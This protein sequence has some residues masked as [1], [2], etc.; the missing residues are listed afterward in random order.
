MSVG[1]QCGKAKVSVLVRESRA[2]R[3]LTLAA[4]TANDQKVAIPRE[5]PL[6]TPSIPPASPPSL[7]SLSP[8]PLFF[9]SSLVV[10]RRHATATR[11]ELLPPPPPPPPLL[12]LTQLLSRVMKLIRV[13]FLF[14]MLSP[15]C[16][17][18][19]FEDNLWCSIPGHLLP[20][21][22]H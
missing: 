2:E 21:V 8:L 22:S 19:M 9:C 6:A 13:F 4:R 5:S 18:L 15:S 11:S 17:L 20:R 1:R 14:L 12:F 7:L 3:Q 16:R 10:D